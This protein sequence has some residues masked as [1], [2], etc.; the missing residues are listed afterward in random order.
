[1]DFIRAKCQIV[2][3]SHRVTPGAGRK[4]S[5]FIVPLL[6]KPFDYAINSLKESFPQGISR[7]VAR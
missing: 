5:G 1:M 2:P 3:A 7:S 4:L 6:K